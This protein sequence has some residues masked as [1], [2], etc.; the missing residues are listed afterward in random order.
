MPRGT[1]EVLLVS[2]KGLDDTDFL[3]NMDPYAVVT[4]RTQEKKSSV[5]K[6]QGSSPEWNETFLFT[7]SSGVTEIRIK[8]MDSDNFSSDDFV[9]EA[10]IPL[11]PAFVVEAM[12]PAAYNVVKDEQYCGEIRVGLK[13]FPQENC[14]REFGNEDNLGGWK[15]S[16]FD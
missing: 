16:S 8:L 2:A 6:G 15:E 14:E 10:I 1:L 13:F 9:G 7:V 3:S 4:C 12:P 11:E 5:A